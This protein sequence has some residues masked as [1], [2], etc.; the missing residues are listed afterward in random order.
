MRIIDLLNKIANGEEVPF[1]VR[2]NITTYLFDE[3]TQDYNDLEDDKAE[4]LF[5]RLFNTIN[6]NWILNDEV[7]ILDEEDEFEDIEPLVLKTF[8]RTGEAITTFRIKDYTFN[9]FEQIENTLAKVI[10][11]QKKIIERLKE[12]R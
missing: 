2:Y 9:N 3:T 4:T 12:I 7:E 5:I 10:L 6:T 1:K 8:E 11:N